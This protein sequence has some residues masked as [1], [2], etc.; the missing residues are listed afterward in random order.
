MLVRPNRFKQDRKKLTRA[1]KISENLDTAIVDY[2][3]K[4]G[5]TPSS[6]VNQILMRHLDWGQY[7]SD[8]SPFV[9]IDKQIF[10]ALIENITEERIVEVARSI[11]LVTT[12]NFIKFRYKKVD[13]RSVLDYF[14]TVSSYMNLGELNTIEDKQGNQL[15][16]IMRH[17]LGIKWSIFLT[18]FVS[19]ILSSFLNME[20][21][22]EISTLGCS[23]IANST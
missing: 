17:A 6:L 12:H 22:S 16:I 10:I 11:A 8:T 5:I 21:H 7:M 2:A 13:E 18:E 14:E 19:G 3:N 1:I 15:E 23:V 9:V 4:I 20:T